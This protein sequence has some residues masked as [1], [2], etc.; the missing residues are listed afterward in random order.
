[1]GGLC[2]AL[3]HGVCSPVIFSLANYTY[4]CRG[5]RRI[6]LCKGILKRMPALSSMWFIFCGLNLGCPPSA[7]FFRECF[8]FCC[9]IGSSWV[10][11]IPLLIM[12]F[13]AAG[14]SLF[15][16][17]SVNH[18][19]QRKLIRRHQGLSTRFL[20]SIVVRG[21]ILF[22]VFINLDVIFV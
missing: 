1:M 5:S 2:I 20:C 6:L 16:Y 3:A 4:M 14:Y 18:G 13:L 22:A 11:I 17:S 7:N 8:L 9:I 19:Y 10:I 21:T 12:C 15:I